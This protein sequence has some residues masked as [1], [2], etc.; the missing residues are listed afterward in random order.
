MFGVARMRV[1]FKF[2]RLGL[3]VYTGQTHWHDQV[4]V[5]GLPS[6]CVSQAV[7]EVASHYT[8]RGSMPRRKLAHHGSSSSLVILKKL[9]L[10]ALLRIAPVSAW[11]QQSHS[12]SPDWSARAVLCLQGHA[13]FSKSTALPLVVRI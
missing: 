2:R 5:C 12:K 4:F 1:F 9:E 7:A 13:V 6:R 3:G 10:E 8:R 11:A